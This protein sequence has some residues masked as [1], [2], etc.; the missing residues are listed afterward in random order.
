MAVAKPAIKWVGAH[1]GNFSVGRQ[2]WAGKPV[3]IEAAGVSVDMPPGF[4]RRSEPD[5]R[6]VNVVTGSEFFQWDAC[7]A[8]DSELSHLIF[9]KAGKSVGRARVR[10]PSMTPLL[11]LVTNVIGLSSKK[12]MIN[13]HTRG[14]ITS[15]ANTHARWDRAIGQLPSKAMRQHHTTVSTTDVQSAIAIV[16]RTEP[17]P[18]IGRLLDVLLKA[19]CRVSKWAGHGCHSAFESHLHTTIGVSPGQ[20]GASCL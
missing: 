17:R 15:M 8:L 1:P 6:P 4:S 18:A 14:V 5:C 11:A 19:N 3:L 2:R 9:S 7:G 12:Q 20:V 16:K 10:S 13:T